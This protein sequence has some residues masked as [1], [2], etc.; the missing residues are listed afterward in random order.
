[1]QEVRPSA[2]GPKVAGFIARGVIYL[3]IAVAFFL[4][5]TLLSSYAHAG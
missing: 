1:V 5:V 3:L 4:I 2:A